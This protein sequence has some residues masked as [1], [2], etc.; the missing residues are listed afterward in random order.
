MTSLQPVGRPAAASPVPRWGGSRSESPWLPVDGGLRAPWLRQWPCGSRTAAARVWWRSL[1]CR[2]GPRPGGCRP[3]STRSSSLAAAAAGCGR[4]HQAR[5]PRTGPG[6][7]PS[8]SPSM[9]SLI[10][11]L[12]LC[13][14]PQRTL[15]L[16]R[17]R[18]P[19]TWQRQQP[20]GRAARRRR[21]GLREAAQ[22][23]SLPCAAPAG[24][25]GG[26]CTCCCRR[27]R[28]RLPLPSPARHQT[29]AAAKQQAAAA[30]AG[31]TARCPRFRRSQGRLC[32]TR[33]LQGCC[34][35]LCMRPITPAAA[36]GCC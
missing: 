22:A 33:G 6:D 35:H 8:P 29:R 4:W 30:S 34:Q 20:V 11:H 10:L 23:L 5:P 16:P 26:A 28:L 21:P 2:H 32:G 13:W 17:L 25:W 19:H 36:A 18:R 7:A 3:C 15:R 12:A 27:P 14:P 9:L 31:T 24:P 1:C